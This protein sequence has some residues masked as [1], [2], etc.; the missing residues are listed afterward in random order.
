MT[1]T[2]KAPAKTKK[3][4]ALPEAT[5][6]SPVGEM[7]ILPEQLLDIIREARKG[8]PEE[9][10]AK[11][12]ARTQRER[13]GQML[14]EQLVKADALKESVQN[15]CSHMKTNGYGQ[16]VGSAVHGQIHSDNMYHG[17]CIRC[18]K[19]FDPIRGDLVPGAGGKVGGASFS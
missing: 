10:E 19:E 1:E 11:L 14:G 16:E 18:F 12:R 15:A 13:S 5:M 17:F 4:T 2:E 7:T 9:E 3:D 8:P 6:K